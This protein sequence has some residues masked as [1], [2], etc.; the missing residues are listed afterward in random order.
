MS[1]T[2]SR[3]RRRS[4]VL[5]DPVNIEAAPIEHL[6]DPEHQSDDEEK[7]PDDETDEARQIRLEKEQEVW[8]AVRE[9]HFEGTRLS[10]LSMNS[11]KNCS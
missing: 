1:S 5:A 2:R 3:K 11:T 6:E 7:V 8:K 10:A 9:E 4:E